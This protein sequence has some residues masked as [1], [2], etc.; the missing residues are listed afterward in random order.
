MIL[1]IIKQFNWLDIVLLILLFRIC[2]VSLIDGIISEFFKI[3]GVITAIYVASHYYT[4]LSDVIV[5]QFNV[6]GLPLQLTDFIVFLFLAAIS[7]S[8]FALLRQALGRVIKMEAISRLNR[9]GGLLLG[10]F[11][12]IVLTGLITF[13]LYISTISYLKISVDKSYLGKRFLNVA[14]ATY[15]WIWENL[16]SKFMVSEKFNDT[17]LEAQGK[18][19]NEI[20]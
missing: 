2:Y 14:P 13:I 20:N 5:K 17:I 15:T 10:V 4:S 11:R 18:E 8:L 6:K 1:D 16:M 7:Y 12:A 3:L 19:K 9:W